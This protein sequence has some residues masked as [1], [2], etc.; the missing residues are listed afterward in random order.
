MTSIVESHPRR[1]ETM[2]LCRWRDVDG[3]RH[4]RRLDG[5][6]SARAFRESL[7]IARVGEAT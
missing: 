6:E 2:Y 3:R 5:E 4:M 7:S 1:A